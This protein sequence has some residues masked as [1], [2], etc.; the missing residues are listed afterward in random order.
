MGRI[1]EISVSFFVRRQSLSMIAVDKEEMCVVTFLHRYFVDR[2]YHTNIINTF[3]SNSY[4]VT[5]FIGDIVFLDNPFIFGKGKNLLAAI[6]REN[7]DETSI[8]F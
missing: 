1:I 8:L 4:L 6:S 5:E 2:I 7:Y 3:I